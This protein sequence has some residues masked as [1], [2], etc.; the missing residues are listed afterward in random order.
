MG[1]GLGLLID[2]SFAYMKRLLK[3]KLVFGFIDV[4]IF[5]EHYFI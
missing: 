4:F 3:N 5:P 2:R 1:E